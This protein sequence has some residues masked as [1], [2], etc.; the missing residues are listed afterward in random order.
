ML[1]P[2]PG[3]GSG[4][5]FGLEHEHECEHEYERIDQLGSEYAGSK[6]ENDYAV[7]LHSPAAADAAESNSN[8]GS[9]S[10]SDSES[11][12]DCESE[13]AAG[14]EIPVESVAESVAEAAHVHFDRFAG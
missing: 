5:G 12:S 2:V 6:V 4:I 10:D 11:Y 7:N 9:G 1:V 14:F 3:T 13:S 8:S